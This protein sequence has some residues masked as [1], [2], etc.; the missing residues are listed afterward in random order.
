MIYIQ[1]IK[2]LSPPSSSLSPGKICTAISGKD[3][4]DNMSGG[5]ISSGDIDE[6]RTLQHH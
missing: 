5:D 6:W 1:N 3:S 2:W 4:I